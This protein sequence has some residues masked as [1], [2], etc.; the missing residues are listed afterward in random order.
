MNSNFLSELYDEYDY[1]EKTIN[2]LCKSEM[3]ILAQNK[4]L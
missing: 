3:N 2:Y 1:K 4:Q